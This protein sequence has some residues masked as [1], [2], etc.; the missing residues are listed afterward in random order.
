MESPRKQFERWREQRPFWGSVLLLTAG[1]LIAWLPLDLT[2]ILGNLPATT[3][4]LFGTLVF[5][6]G[7]FALLRPSV[8]GG[9]GVAGVV[10]SILSFFGAYG[11]FLVG[12]FVGILGGSLTYAWVPP[13]EH[14]GGG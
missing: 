1:V 12:M 8:H 9:L 4:L 5:M 11:G 7:V 10:F 2:D 6:T 14:G 13:H 3:G